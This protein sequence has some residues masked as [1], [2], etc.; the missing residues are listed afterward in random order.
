[1]KLLLFIIV[2]FLSP[3]SRDLVKSSLVM[4]LSKWDSGKT[5]TGKFL[6]DNLVWGIKRRKK[7]YWKCKRMHCYLL[8]KETS[9]GWSEVDQDFCCEE[10]GIMDG[11]SIAS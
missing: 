4:V 8:G 1:M 11:D 9:G 3:T 2:K 7:W 5:L 6:I 10:E